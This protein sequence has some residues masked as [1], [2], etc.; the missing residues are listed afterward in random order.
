MGKFLLK[1]RGLVHC[2]SEETV[3]E[4]NNKKN[5]YKKLLKV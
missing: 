3:R 2:K 4:T 1:H 5:E